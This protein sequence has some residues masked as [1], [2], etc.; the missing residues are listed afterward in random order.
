MNNGRRPPIEPKN[1]VVAF[2]L[3]LRRENCWSGE[4]AEGKSRN[5]RA[6]LGWRASGDSVIAR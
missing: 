5:G 4:L 3:G 2:T 1:P 6:A